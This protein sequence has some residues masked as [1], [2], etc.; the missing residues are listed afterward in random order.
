MGRFKVRFKVCSIRDP[1]KC[2]EVEGWVDTGATLSVIPKEIL[3]E[4]GIE[5][6]R[7]QDFG[8]AACGLRIRRK[9]GSANIRIRVNG[10]EEEVTTEVV[11]GEKGDIVLLG[12]DVFEHLGLK[13]DPKTGK[14]IQEL[15]YL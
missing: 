11:F 6:K 1:N 5:P 3:E 14:I 13:I 4:L 7:E 2:K 8:L 9:V 15:A 12:V 10:K